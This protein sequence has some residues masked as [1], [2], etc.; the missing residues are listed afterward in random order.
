MAMEA[1][2]LQRCALLSILMG[3]LSDPAAAKDLV[4][5]CKGYQPDDHHKLTEQIITLDVDNKRV[6]SI[7][8]AGAGPRDLMNAPMKVGK[9]VLEWPYDLLHMKYVFNRQNSRLRLFSDTMI[10]LGIFD[11]TST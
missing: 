9:D 1:R 5:H 10:L 7:Q 8:L 6:V 3:A 2:L 11:C 4:L